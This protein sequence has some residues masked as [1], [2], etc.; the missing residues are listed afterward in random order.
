MP[1]KRHLIAPGG[2]TRYVRRTRTGQFTNE[3]ED[4]GRSLTQD[5]RRRAKRVAKAGYGDTGDRRRR[6]PLRATRAKGGRKK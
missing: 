5:R 6:G 2:D 3:Q 1:G 4:V